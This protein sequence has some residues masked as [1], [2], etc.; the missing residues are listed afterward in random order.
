MALSRS[1]PCSA[2]FLSLCFSSFTCFSPSLLKRSRSLHSSSSRKRWR[3]WNS[4]LISRSRTSKRFWGK[5][6]FIHRSLEFSW[7]NRVWL[8]VIKLQYLNFHWLYVSLPLGFPAH[9]YLMFDS[10]NSLNKLF[11]QHK[12]THTLTEENLKKQTRGTGELLILKPLNWLIHYGT[13]IMEYIQSVC[14]CFKLKWLM[15][16]IKKKWSLPF[17][18]GEAFFYNWCWYLCCSFG[19]FQLCKTI[20]SKDHKFSEGNVTHK[21]QRKT[22]SEGH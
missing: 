8:K 5:R 17:D 3:F 15:E 16:T 1:L 10:F 14:C 21:V 20:T 19:T 6:T 12:N 11:L 18:Q 9:I 13:C 22:Q 2:I 4:A 7:K